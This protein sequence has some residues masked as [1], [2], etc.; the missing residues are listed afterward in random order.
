MTTQELRKQI[1]SFF[2]GNL[3]E[4]DEQALRD[5]LATHEVPQDML[6]E[7]R[8]VLTLVP[9]TPQIPE[10]LEERLSSFIDRL[11]ARKKATRFAPV[12]RWVSGVAAIVILASAA[13]LYFTR[14]PA[15]PQLS[16]QEIYACAEAQRALLLVS[17]KLNEGTQ[18]W[19]EAQQEIVKTNRIINKHLK[20]K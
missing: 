9:G 19:Q 7:K 17:Q 15:Q 6:E 11:P 1:D 8:I 14:Q 5:Y 10:G 4:T 16:E 3:S 2:D 18:Q 12:W 20:I 13:G